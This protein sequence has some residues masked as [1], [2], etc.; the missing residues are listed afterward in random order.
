MRVR[1]EGRMPALRM[2]MSK[3]E[4]QGRMLGLLC[5]SLPLFFCVGTL[6][7]PGARL[8]ATMPQ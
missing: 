6:I 1:V 4:G 2:S 5:D 3:D 8:E 7:R